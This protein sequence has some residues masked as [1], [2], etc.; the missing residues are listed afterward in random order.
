TPFSDIFLL[1]TI[2]HLADPDAC[3]CKAAS[4]LRPGGRIHIGTPDIKAL[5]PR[6][7]GKKWRNITP[8]SH[9]HY[10]S[11]KSLGH[12]LQRHGLNVIRTW[13]PPVYRNIRLIWYHLITRKA[14]SAWAENVQR[15]IPKNL[16]LPI[17]TFDNM[18]V[19]ATKPEN[20][21]RK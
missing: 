16:T 4:E 19:M 21:S 3:V 1:D 13:H 8:P 7:R 11:P 10:F 14:S 9:L 20:P 2:E 6:L 17:N 15:L 18:L 12:L 5:L